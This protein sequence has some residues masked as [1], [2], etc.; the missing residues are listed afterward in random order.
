[1]FDKVRAWLKGSRTS[2]GETGATLWR[3]TAVYTLRDLYRSLDERKRPEDIAAMILRTGLASS[4]TIKSLKTIAGHADRASSMSSDFNR[5]YAHLDRQAKVAS[6]LFAVD[7]PTDSADVEAVNQ[8]LTKIDALIGK[9]FGRSD[10]KQDRLN[11]EQRE[12]IGID[13]S[14]R[15][16]NKRFRLTARM[17]DK[18]R[19]RQREITRRS[20]TLASKSR[21]ASQLT[22]EQ[23]STDAPTACFITYYVAR[24]NV[25]SLFTVNEQV[26]PF[27]KTCEVMMRGLTGAPTTNWLALAYVMP[28]EEV[29]RR[30]SDHDKGVLLG[31]YFEMLVKAGQF[32]EEVW[33]SGGLNVKTMIV[34][35]GNDSTT[36][37]V[38]A[39]AWNKLRDGWFNL[40]H[41]LGA[42]DIIERQCFG[43]VMRL[44]AAD[45]AQWHRSVKGEDTLH[46]DTTVWAE[47]PLPWLV[48]RGD[49]DCTRDQVEQLCR[50]YA[51]DPYKSGW[52]A[53]RGEKQV[54]A[55]APTPDLVHGV[56][57]SSPTMARAMRR[58]GIFSGKAAKLHGVDVDIETL[59]AATETARAE[60]VVG[61]ME[62]KLA[63]EKVPPAVG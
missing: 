9:T 34:A 45:V 37:N 28:D 48:L 44:M 63:N 26:R 60:H 43:K 2:S 21:L 5:S 33:K 56:V 1:M 22:W 20:L 57:V 31:R 55:F 58:A 16:Y 17:E 23:F 13:I 52:I 24:C 12:K 29:V 36:W 15:Q 61:E 40:C 27:D 47:L 8:Y 62:R 35:R 10:Y 54:A 41:A 25:R 4:E 39:G 30:L 42:D 19:R 14:R 32:L 51:I 6:I 3:D 11:K 7:A 50:R 49:A 53:R 59:I 46:T 38:M 18:V